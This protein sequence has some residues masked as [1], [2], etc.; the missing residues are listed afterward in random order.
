VLHKIKRQDCIIQYPILPLRHYDPVLDD[1][2]YTY[3]ELYQH[4]IFT[5]DS[6][7]YRG[8]TSQLT[9]LLQY[10]CHQLDTPFLVFLGD[11]D[12][13]WQGQ[14]NDY[15][16]AKAAQQYLTDNKV[17]KRF[18]GGLSVAVADL[19]AFIPHFCWL[20]RS[21]AALPYFHFTDAAQSFMG[22]ICKYGNLHVATKLQDA[23][24]PLCAA[25]LQKGF[26]HLDTESCYYPFNDT[27]AIPGRRTII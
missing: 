19:A 20:T 2:I 27:G 10:C 6:K 23:D 7:T 12:G 26:R 21:N 22:E 3:P 5:R 24:A 15:A 14:D 4:H 17:G 11:T 9:K 13:P 25:F 1:E 8:H 16:P 18:N